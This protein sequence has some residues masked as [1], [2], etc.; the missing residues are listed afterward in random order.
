M[1]DDEDEEEPYNPF[2]ESEKVS[3]ASVET[4]EED[5][6]DESEAFKTS[7]DESLN[8]FLASLDINDP[9]SASDSDDDDEF[10]PKT[11]A[12]NEPVEESTQSAAE[13]END[14]ESFVTPTLGEIYAAQGQYAKAIEVFK[15]LIKKNPNNEW[16]Q[17][18]IDFLQ[19][20][21][22]ESEE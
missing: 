17:S 7:D 22:D 1:M 16:Y 2:E 20:K 6:E 8:D 9:S 11:F 3:S 19:K 21:L 4:G 12:E 10:E 18:K 14:S 5:E 15:T 13:N